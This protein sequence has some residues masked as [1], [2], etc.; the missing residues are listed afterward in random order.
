MLI[1]P[2]NIEGRAF[3]RVQ[4]SPKLLLFLV[5]LMNWPFA[6][7][8]VST[9]SPEDDL[10][11]CLDNTQKGD[12]LLLQEGLY[13]GNFVINRSIRISGKPGAILDGLGEGNALII[14]APNVTVTDLRIVNWGKDLTA[15]NAGIFV[16]KPADNTR[17]SRLELKGDGFGVWVDA[18]TN[19]KIS[20]NHIQGN[21][22]IRSQDRGN[23]IHLFNVSGAQVSNNEVWHTRDGIYID[24]SN[25]N[26]LTGNYLHDLR[27]GIHYMYSY[28]NQVS[29]N[30]TRHTRTGYALMQSKYLTVTDNRS[31]EDVNY[32][33][34]MNF[35]T[36]SHIVGNEVKSVRNALNTHMRHSGDGYQ[37]EGKAMFI[38]NSLFNRVHGNRLMDSDIGI[39]LTAGS[40]DNSFMNN[41][42][43]NNTKQVKYVANRSQDWSKD[44]FGNYWSDYLGWD[45]NDDGI[46]DIAY[47]PNDGIDRLL[48]KYP[49]VKVLINSPAVIM[50]RWVQG[51]FPV[52]KAPGVKD[53]YPLMALPQGR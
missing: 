29:G 17:L 53:S 22:N 39:H 46:G 19:I 5:L 21:E 43:I 24:T 26:S 32:G 2:S 40:E 36:H 20:D 13:R 50:L 4:M 42:F 11:A 18:A 15:M 9:V 30:R 34:L 47:E 10:Q 44:G 31:E 3:F 23:G 14:N 33:I 45:L 12:H 1:R 37:P 6:W 28:H 38:Y 49:M 8:A 48:W 27:Y 52:L 16:N 51:Q 35:I 7:S 41:A 25:G